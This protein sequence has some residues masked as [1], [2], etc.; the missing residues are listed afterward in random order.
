[1]HVQLQKV[2]DSETPRSS[3]LSLEAVSVSL[4]DDGYA[5]L[6]LKIL[7]LIC[8]GQNKVLQDYM[9]VQPD[10]IKSLNIVSEVATF[11]GLLYTGINHE[12]VGLTTELL[13]T[14]VEFC[15]VSMM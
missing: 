3:L 15:S 14:L 4:K 8:D 7:G 12:T 11:F 1:M 5:L 9:C 13:N 6:I 2:S 10:N